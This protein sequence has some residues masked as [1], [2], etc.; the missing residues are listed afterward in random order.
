MISRVN[1]IKE[2]FGASVVVHTG[3]GPIFIVL[4]YDF[5]D[6]NAVKQ[7]LTIYVSEKK[8]ITGKYPWESI[9][10]L[11]MELVCVREFA[12][13]MNMSVDDVEFRTAAILD[14]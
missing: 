13:K 1:V 11:F 5:H 2:K 4:S 6:Q 7:K 10:E 3:S 9:G 12:E 14:Q 8:M